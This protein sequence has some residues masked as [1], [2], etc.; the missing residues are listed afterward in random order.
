LSLA[1]DLGLGLPMEHALRSCLIALRLAERAGLD[2]AERAV[3]YYVGLLAWVGCHA[4]A[5]EQAAWFGDDIARKAD[6]SPR[7]WS[8]SA[9]SA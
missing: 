8:G 2:E 7:S 1:I 3:V 4:D 5:Y 6:M 9:G